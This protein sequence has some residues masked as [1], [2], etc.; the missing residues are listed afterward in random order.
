MAETNTL[1]IILNKKQKKVIK[2]LNGNVVEE[3]VSGILTMAEEC[4][5]VVESLR[6]TVY[7]KH[8]HD[9]GNS[10]YVTFTY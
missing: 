7:T 2:M 10:I 4:Y 9:D 3:K 8:T 5:K 6:D 1:V